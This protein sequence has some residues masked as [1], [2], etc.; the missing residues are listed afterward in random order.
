[1][2]GYEIK[3]LGEIGGNGRLRVPRLGDCKNCATSVPTTGI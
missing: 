3:A 1:M 2:Y